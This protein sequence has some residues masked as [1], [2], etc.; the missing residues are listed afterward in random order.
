VWCVLGGMARM[1]CVLGG[2]ARSLYLPR[3]SVCGQVCVAA[4]V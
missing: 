4:C 1:V 3:V 2:M